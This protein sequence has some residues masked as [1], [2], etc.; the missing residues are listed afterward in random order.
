MTRVAI[1]GGGVAAHTLVSALVTEHSNRPSGEDALTV[2]VFSSEPHLPY[3]RPEVNKG[4][5][6]SG[7]TPADI[8]LAGG[9]FDT[10]G[11]TFHPSTTVTSVDPATGTLTAGN[12]TH[13]FDELVFATGA[14]PRLLDPGDPSNAHLHGRDI[15]HIRTPEHSHALRDRLTELGDGNT[16]VVIGGGVLGLEAAAAAS[17]LSAAQ[18]HVLEIADEVCTRILPPT[19]ARWLR[20]RHRDHGVTVTCGLPPD[21]LA[22]EVT[23]LDPAL[24]IVSVGAVR[25]TMLAEDAGIAVGEGL[26]GGICV[27]E[28]GRTAVPGIYAAGDCAEIHTADGRVIRP[29][30]DGSA[31]LLAGIVAAQLNGGRAGTAFTDSP[32]KGWTRQFGHMLNTVGTTGLTAAPAGGATGRASGELTE[33]V[34]LDTPEELIVLTRDGD[35]VVGVTTVGR[36][37]EVR[38]AKASLGTV[39]P[40]SS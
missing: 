7:K 34:V 32:R 5:L 3:R 16:V 20:D 1:V 31:R 29:E 30:D 27:D 18:V 37:A 21:E 24:V 26:G 9:I 19:A 35:T 23:R 38:A 39:S 17:S 14:G 36:S 15:H 13:H 8:A 6:L 12:T 22:G 10:P 4:I 28:F 11:I 2:D 40:L 33:E 25:D